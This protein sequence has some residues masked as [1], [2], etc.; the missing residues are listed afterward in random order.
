[1]LEFKM[2]LIFGVL[3]VSPLILFYAYRGARR[4]AH[5]S[6]VYTVKKNPWLF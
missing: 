4:Q 2:S 3:I 6:S 1:M 5:Q